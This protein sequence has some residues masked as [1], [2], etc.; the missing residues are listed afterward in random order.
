MGEV[1]DRKEQAR[2]RFRQFNITIQDL[3]V[4]LAV[5]ECLSFS[6]AAKLVG[7]SQPS[8]SSRIIKL[9]Q[10]LR[11]Q[12]FLR[13]ANSVR[14]SDEGK[15]FQIDAVNLVDEMANLH[16]K[17]HEK[18]ERRKSVV[19]VCSP[20]M[21]GLTV[22]KVSADQFQER[23]PG[24]MLKF[25]DDTPENCVQRVI[26]GTS[27]V[28]VVPLIDL[29][30]NADFRLVFTDICNAIS[31]PDH[32][33]TRSKSAD[34]AEILKYPI[35]CPDSH[36]EIRKNLQIE[37]DKR[38]IKISFVPEAFGITNYMSLISMASS[39]LGVAITSAKFIP[40]PFQQGIGITKI[41]GC[42]LTRAF[43]LVTDNDRKPSA[44]VKGFCDYLAKIGSLMEI[45]RGPI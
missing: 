10:R 4:F 26:D 5:A 25:A 18:G 22:A 15:R 9:E 8:V 45:A 19:R 35:L 33:L 20:I 31:A 44:S 14:L 6:G 34:I 27:D 2:M 30:P 16:D 12:L 21:I 23:N 39:N 24:I 37:A 41:D 36:I 40:E 42:R 28:A 13:D 38:N 17:Y 32:P 3:Q 7:K 1:G 11:T 29:P 43:G